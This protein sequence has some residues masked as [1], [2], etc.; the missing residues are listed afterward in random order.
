MST[1][2]S[3]LRYLLLG[4]LA[5]L[6]TVPATARTTTIK[7]ASLAPNN[8]IWDEVVEEMGADWSEATEGRV[9]LRVYP[10][11]VAGDE[12]AVVRKMRIG[13]LQGAVLTPEGLTLLDSSFGVFGIP[14]LFESYDELYH[15]LDELTPMFEQSL[16][17]Q[18]YVLLHWGNAGWVHLFSSTPVRTLDDLRK[19]RLFTSAGD[20]SALQ[21]WKDGGFRPVPL[22]K[23]DILTSLETGLIDALPSPPLAALLLQWY[24]SAPYLLDVGF[25]PLVGATVVD[26]KTWDKL[27]AEDQKALLTAAREAGDRLAEEVPS[28]DERSI[29][30]MEKRG[31]TVVRVAGSP[32]ETEWRD[33]AATFAEKVGEGK[34]PAEVLRRVLA[35]RDRY[36]ARQSE[37]TP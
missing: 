28:Q 17:K 31:L 14:F 33:L 16:A 11:G 7:V 36:R 2:C 25:A 15:V 9:R 32:Q 5:L 18:G 29:A 3:F 20:D 21:W 37:V 10:G 35:V 23:T 6:L 24:Q 19:V 30:E 27:S 12:P 34:V 22:A 1:S 8:S 26:Q 4:G 13:Q